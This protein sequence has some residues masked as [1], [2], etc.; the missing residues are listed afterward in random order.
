VITVEQARRVAGDR[1]GK[2]LV[3]WAWGAVASERGCSDEPVDGRFAPDQAVRQSADGNADHDGDN[4]NGISDTNDTNDTNNDGHGRHIGQP[5]LKIALHPPS[6]RHMLADQR[7]AEAWAQLWRE[8]DNASCDGL[9][10]DWQER[11]WRS[12][13]RQKIPV[14]VA[15]CDASA[16]AGFVG[17]GLKS[18]WLK[19]VRRFCILA[20]RF[21]YGAAVADAVRHH[22]ARL[23][24][25]NEWDFST[26]VEVAAW[27]AAHT[28]RGMRPR[29]LPIRGIDTKWFGRHRALVEEFAA[30]ARSAQTGRSAESAGAVLREPMTA[31]LGSGDAAAAPVRDFG[32]VS[33]D[34]LIR[35]R[36]LDPALIEGPIVDFA[37][38]TS[39]LNTLDIESR[40]LFVF[41]NLENVLAM[42]SPWPGAVVIHGGGFAVDAVAEIPW[43]QQRH[44]IYWGDLDSHGFAILHRLRCHHPSVESVM[45]DVQT[46]QE[47]RDL[48]VTEPVP[49]RGAFPTLTS[50]ESMARERLA[51][52]GDVRLEQERIPWDVA[53]ER[54]REVGMRTTPTSNCVVRMN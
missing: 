32:I 9:S 11:A 13:G 15:F 53:L 3:A 38:P 12:I 35:M 19:A 42:P 14:R 46:L 22:G 39:Q 7:A 10:I 4:A 25:L 20:E 44:I 2:N 6:E 33:N 41:E 52:E 26:A 43:V 18:R 21:G 45:M 48:W 1:L 24:E 51:G 31:S 23:L 17:G 49:N 36:I 37:A 27:L 8:Q 54:L 40:T 16:V 50:E 47:Y 29:Q 30:A 28:V 34:P 5:V